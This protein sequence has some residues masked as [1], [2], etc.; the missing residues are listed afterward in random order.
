MKPFEMYLLTMLICIILST[1]MNVI[2][3]SRNLQIYLFKDST[4]EIQKAVEDAFRQGGGVVHVR[5]AKLTT[6][7]IFYHSMNLITLLLITGFFLL[8][9]VPE[10]KALIYG[11][12]FHTLHGILKTGL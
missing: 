7:G 5:P 3:A 11:S 12:N 10:I 9:T 6:Y 2:H 8:Q 1:T 4:Q